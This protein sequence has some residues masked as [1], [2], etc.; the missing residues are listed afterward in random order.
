[1]NMPLCK[2]AY[3]PLQYCSKKNLSSWPELCR[4]KISHFGDEGARTPQ[5]AQLTP[6]ANLV[7]F[8]S[9]HSRTLRDWTIT[10]LPTTLTVQ[11]KREPF[12]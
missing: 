7:E 8:D 11:L 12:F 9:T 5:M 3:K 2:L 1:M 6:H 4:H 10:L